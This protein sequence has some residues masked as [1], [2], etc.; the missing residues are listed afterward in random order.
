M[1]LL[2][3]VPMMENPQFSRFTSNAVRETRDLIEFGN[4]I[5]VLD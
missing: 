2:E 1:E 5:T 4:A 3:K